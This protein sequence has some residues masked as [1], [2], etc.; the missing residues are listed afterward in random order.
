MR[1]TSQKTGDNL[2]ESKVEQKVG[3]L[4][5]SKQAEQQRL[6]LE[7]G[8]RELLPAF[9]FFCVV[10]GKICLGRCVKQDARQ[11]GPLV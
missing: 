2:Q 7:A 6:W 11:N 9:I 4:V 1:V 8:M 10:S 3:W 5:Q